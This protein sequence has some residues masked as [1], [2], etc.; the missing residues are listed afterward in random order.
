[1]AKFK[2]ELLREAIADADAIKE[3]AVANAKLYLEES[4][5]PHVRDAIVNQLNEASNPNVGLDPHGFAEV[6]EGK[7]SVDLKSSGVGSSGE[8]GSDKSDLNSLSDKMGPGP[9][10]SNASGPAASLSTSGIGKDGETS[11]DEDRGAA[12]KSPEDSEVTLDNLTEEED[13]EESDVEEDVDLTEELN[14]DAIIRELQQEV[15]SLRQ[16]SDQ[17][18]MGGGD[19]DYDDGGMGADDAYQDG[20]P[21][22]GMGDGG[23]EYSDEDEFGAGADMGMDAEPEDGMGAELDID[24]S[25]DGEEEMEEDFDLDGILR[26]IE[27]ELSEEKEVEV[28]EQNKNLKEE[29]SEYRAAV[30]LLRDKLNEVNILNAKLLY[31]NKLFRVQNLSEDQKLHVIGQFDRATTLR[32]AKLIYATLAENLV[33]ATTKRV[34]AKNSTTITE[35][36]ASSIVGSTRPSKSPQVL[37]EN[38]NAFK[39]RMQV[40]AGITK[41][42]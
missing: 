29:L 12:K 22:V 8:S 42:L 35:G 40:I 14:L 38:D 2:N 13:I 4:I 28:A 1:M 36:V 3:T 7:E 17:Q 41:V 20:E 15:D 37:N 10:Q 16:V 23:D 19:M 33:L 30:E 26:E 5:T 39:S 11:G 31:T 6:T 9:E 24:P 34:A 18:R 25:L 32:E 27:A 21:E